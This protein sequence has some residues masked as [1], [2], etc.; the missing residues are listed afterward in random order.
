MSFDIN[1]KLIF[2]DTFQFWSS[3]LDSLVKNL[4]KY[5]FKYL[6]SDFESNVLH[7]VEQKGF[8]LH[9]YISNFEKI[10]EKLPSKEWIDPK[11]FDLNKYNSLKGYVLKVD[12][13]C[14]KELRE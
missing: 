1:N 10:E 5:D 3:S 12:F 2:V 4:N 13:E 7:L 6:S 9:E 11:N 14:P 8:Y